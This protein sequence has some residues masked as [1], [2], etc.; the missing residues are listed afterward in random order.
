M[1]KLDKIMIGFYGFIF[2]S[3]GILISMGGLG[4]ISKADIEQLFETYNLNLDNKILLIIIG[5]VVFLIGISILNI[6]LFRKKSPKT[7]F[8]KTDNGEVNIAFAAIE[9][10]I[11][12]IVLKIQEV[13]DIK[14]KI[15]VKGKNLKVFGKV[16]LNT[17]TAVTDI[18]EKIQ[19][20]IVEKLNEMLGVN[21]KVNVFINVVKVSSVQNTGVVNT[22]KN[23]DDDESFHGIKY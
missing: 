21:I 15:Q 22:P 11:K 6:I 16:V 23:N 8:I 10:F 19:E 1:N 13:K 12:R 20:Q 18:V 3:I 9:D 14:I 5:V 2:M 17:E 4:Y 7:L